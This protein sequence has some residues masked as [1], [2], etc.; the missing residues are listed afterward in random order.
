MSVDK[1]PAAAPIQV[2]PFLVHLDAQGFITMADPGL[3]A[4]LGYEKDEL[5]GKPWNVLINPSCA[6][7]SAIEDLWS[8][9]GA[10]LHQ[11]GVYDFIGK[12]GEPFACDITFVPFLD[13]SHN[14]SKVSAL[15]KPVAAVQS[16]SA[17]QQAMNNALNR[18]QAVAEFDL[19]GFILSANQNFL[20][21]FGF[22]A[23]E[24]VGQHHR[25]FC[26]ESF[27]RSSAYRDFWERL[28]QGEFEAGQYRRF[29]NN[30]KEIWIQASYN[31]VFDENG[32]AVK[33][34]KFATDITAAKLRSFEFEAQ[35]KALNRVQAVIELDT[36]GFVVT[37]NENFLRTMDYTLEE[38]Q[39]RHHR[40]F[41]DEAYSRTPAYKEFWDKL[42]RGEFDLGEYK[43]FAKGGREVW[44]QASYNPVLD[45]DG[46]PIKII[47]FATDVTS[48]RLRNSDYEA[49][50][51]AMSRSQAV[52]EFDV[53]GNVLSANDNFLELLGYTAREVRGKHH[54]IFCTPEF[55]QSAE[56]RHFWSRL[57]R[58]EFYQ[59]RFLRIGKLGHQVWIQATYSPVLDADGHPYKVIKFATDITAQVQR[60]EQLTIKARAMKA[61]LDLMME[62]V[63]EILQGVA[64]TVQSN[65]R[66]E[67]QAQQGR[68]AV[69]ESL[70]SI[71]AIRKSGTD[72]SEFVTVVAEIAGQTNLLAFNAAIEAARAGEHGLGFSVVADEVRKLAERATQATREITRLMNESAHCAQS[73]QEISRRAQDSF[74]GITDGLSA[75]GKALSGIGNTT[76]KQLATLAGMERTLQ[77]LAGTKQSELASA[78]SGAALAE[79]ALTE[80]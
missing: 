27:T 37:A 62:T 23:Q 22:T 70:Q 46:R 53:E 12:N 50:S 68:E 8:N 66:S 58:G 80:A 4:N 26:D 33:V 60:E 28:G 41:C 20:D 16:L 77:E 56:Y 10:G 5:V 59:G 78:A 21:I 43:R 2:Q 73:G 1:N 24:L 34:I 36:R 29:G 35:A 11:S 19:R 67:T 18:V 69:I 42:G 3:P 71:G 38:I 25:M 40:M 14:L 51:N 63:K 32:K 52:I 65:A 9:L 48:S 72:I 55:V 6:E 45:S 76:D 47:K 61:N 79:P 49:K 39:G 7:S 15:V 75:V 13:A 44:L 54:K 31:P 57:G 64:S 74:Q 30:N 17:E